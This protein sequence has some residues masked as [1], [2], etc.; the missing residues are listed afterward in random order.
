LH[1]LWIRET[2]FVLRSG[3]QQIFGSEGSATFNGIMHGEA[4]NSDIEGHVFDFV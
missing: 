2:P 3:G 1:S 4:L